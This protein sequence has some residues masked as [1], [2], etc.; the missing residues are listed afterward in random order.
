MKLNII[1]LPHRKDR[2]ELLLGQLEQQGIIDYY[3]WEGIVDIKITARGISQAHKQIV[4]YAKKNQLPEVL[5]AE[6]DLKFTAKGAFNFF[7]ENK[8]IDFDLY[9]ASIYLGEIKNDNT[10]NDFSGLTFYIVREKF[11][12]LFLSMPEHD[13]LDRLMKGQG[14][15]CVCNPFTVVQHNGF[16]DNVNQY[17]NYDNFL[18]GRELFGS[19]NY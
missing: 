6:D 2:K 18:M 12:N 4:Q 8:P 14:K 9:L 1:H 16:S 19:K 7:L 13:N 5:I 17:C 11:Y 3:I 10:V 15:F